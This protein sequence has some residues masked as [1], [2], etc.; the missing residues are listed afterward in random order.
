MKEKGFTIIETTVATF[1]IFA[2]SA[3]SV[4]PIQAA[5]ASYRLGS[6][7]E[8][9]SATFYR[10]RSEAVSKNA[11]VDVLFSQTGNSYG[12]DENNNGVLDPAEAIAL[13]AGTTLGLPTGAAEPAVIRFTSRGE[14][15]IT[16]ASPVLANPPYVQV[17]GGGRT[18][19]VSVSLR[20]S[21]SIT[22]ITG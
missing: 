15:P 14:M 2:V 18:Q 12:I 19:Q 9:I 11:N 16:A 7:A 22:T 13:P 21:V 20:G 5:L 10:A 6:T 4:K 1:I 3:I 8:G 17:S